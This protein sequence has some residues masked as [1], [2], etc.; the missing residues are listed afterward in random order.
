MHTQMKQVN[1]IARDASLTMSS[2]TVAHRLIYTTALISVFVHVRLASI[3]TKVKIPA[4][5]ASLGS[6]VKAG[7]AT[8]S[9]VLLDLFAT[10]QTIFQG[11]SQDDLVDHLD[12]LMLKTGAKEKK[13]STF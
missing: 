6:V 9:L 2:K 1:E 7:R 12:N 8:Q 5:I 3:L 13:D 11:V 4:Q 10:V